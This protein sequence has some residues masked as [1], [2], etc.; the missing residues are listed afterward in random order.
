MFWTGIKGGNFGKRSGKTVGLFQTI[1]S[2]RK[3]MVAPLFKT[4]PDKA[5]ENM[6]HGTIT[7]LLGI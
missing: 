6:L 5:L 3:V 7:A 1:N 4:R 2:P